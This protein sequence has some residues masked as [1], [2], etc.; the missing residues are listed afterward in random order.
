M[1]NVGEQKVMES[2]IFGLT[3]SL[4]SKIFTPVATMVRPSEYVSRFELLEGWN[5]WSWEKPLI[6]VI[7][8]VL[9]TL[10]YLIDVFPAGDMDFTHQIK[11][12]KASKDTKEISRNSRKETCG[13]K[14]I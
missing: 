7:T 11:K 6:F 13:A 12:L 1:D 4:Q 5:I 10:Y 14:Q 8:F 2:A 3:E 9:I